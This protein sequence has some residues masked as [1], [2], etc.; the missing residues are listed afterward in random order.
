M[1]LEILEVAALDAFA[2]VVQGIEIGGGGMGQGLQAGPQ[3]GAVHHLEHD[4][5]AL[6]LFAQQVADALAFGP[7]RHAAGG[8]GVDAVFFLHT[9]ADDVVAVS[10]AAVFIDEI[11]G[12][13]KDGN[14]LGAG[15]VAFDAGQHRVNDVVHQ[16]VLAVGDEDLVAGQGKGAVGVAYGRGGQVADV[17]SGFRFGQQHGAAPLAGV[18]FFQIGFFL[19]VRYRN[20]RSCSRCRRPSNH[21]R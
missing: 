2:G 6:L 9:G 15:R 10:Q 16:V 1:I 20:S 17:G 13:D 8:A 19:V 12:H 11:F 7:Q 5:H 3:S 21:R 4:L 18:E 14:A